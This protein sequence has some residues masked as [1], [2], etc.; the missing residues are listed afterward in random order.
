MENPNSDETL[1]KR[2]RAGDVEAFSGIVRRHHPQL[3][4]LCRSILEDA[5][6][7]ED[8]A[9][10]IFIKAYRAVGGFQGESSFSTWLYRI[11]SNHCLNLLR[12]RNREKTKS[13]DAILEREGESGFRRLSAVDGTAEF[14]EKRDI[15]RALL[16]SLLPEYRM[17]LTLRELQG[18]TYEEIAQ[19]MNCSLDSVKARLRR[20]RAQLSERMRHFQESKN[21]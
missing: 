4:R 15:L 2:V 12:K 20:A 1:V 13:W 10:E 5:A 18:Y 3:L 17:A 8:A 11:A 16:S 19:A 9:Q 6:Q 21:V 14:M 7:S